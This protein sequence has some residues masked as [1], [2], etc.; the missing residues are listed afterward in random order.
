VAHI[1]E[2]KK[3][4][5]IVDDIFS[6][7]DK[8]Y[9]PKTVSGYS[10]KILFL[11]PEH[12]K[13]EVTWYKTSPTNTSPGGNE[14]ICI[15]YYKAIKKGYSSAHE[16]DTCELLY[17]GGTNA[18]VNYTTK[19]PY[20]EA[21]KLAADFINK[22]LENSKKYS[23]P[24]HKVYQFAPA[25]DIFTA[26]D[27]VSINGFSWA[28]IKPVTIMPDG[29]INESEICNPDKEV[30]FL[31][32]FQLINVCNLISGQMLY[33]GKNSFIPVQGSGTK[34][35]HNK[36]MSGYIKMS[37]ITTKEKEILDQLIAHYSGEIK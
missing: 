3:M 26:K 37:M 35:A 27:T 11:K 19:Y 28:K 15:R 30:Y 10:D 36:F 33:D 24:I 4:F 32:N 21:I 29:I 34:R 7:V 18:I 5:K 12:C 1:R 6:L 2:R 22:K 31:V 13:I 8:K 25:Q 17:D 14:R 9:S 16:E 20:Q 23:V